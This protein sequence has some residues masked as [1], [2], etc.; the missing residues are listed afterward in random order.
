M[1]DTEVVSIKAVEKGAEKM[2][3]KEVRRYLYA[4]AE[5]NLCVIILWTAGFLVGL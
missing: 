4:I 1:T 3:K 2:F 5:L